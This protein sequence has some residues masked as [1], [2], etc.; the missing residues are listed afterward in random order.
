MNMRNKCQTCLYRG[1]GASYDMCQ[2]CKWGTLVT[3]NY[4]KNPYYKE[5]YTDHT[6][7]YKRKYYIEQEEA[8]EEKE[9]TDAINKRLEQQINEFKERYPEVDIK[10]VAHSRI[11][12]ELMSKGMS[13]IE[14]YDLVKAENE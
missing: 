10:C 7:Y 9:R 11:I 14:A 6:D 2:N 8:K 1:I 4:I 3:D 13:I 5:G 12:R